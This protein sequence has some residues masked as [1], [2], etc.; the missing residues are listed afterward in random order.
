VTKNYSCNRLHVSEKKF[1]SGYRVFAITVHKRSSETWFG[2]TVCFGLHPP[3][4]TLKNNSSV[5]S[6]CCHQS[7]QILL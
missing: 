7:I 4:E 3:L 5:L 1:W 2:N 6:Y